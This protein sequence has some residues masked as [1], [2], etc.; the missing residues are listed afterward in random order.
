MICA[1]LSEPSWRESLMRIA[2][3]AVFIICALL[4]GL[5]FRQYAISSVHRPVGTCGA[6]RSILPPVFNEEPTSPHDFARELLERGGVYV[7]DSSSF[8]PGGELI[9]KASEVDRVRAR[10][11]VH[12]GVEILL[13][14]ALQDSPY[15]TNDPARAQLFVVPQFSSVEHLRCTDGGKYWNPCDDDVARYYLMPIIR[16]VQE[17]ATYKRRGGSDHLWIFSMDFGMDRF[18]G[19]SDALQSNWYWGYYGP[20][21]NHLAVPSP[22]STILSA[23]VVQSAVYS[24]NSDY[25]GTVDALAHPGF[26]GVASGL[27]EHARPRSTTYLAVF[28][29]T[30]EQAGLPSYSHGIRQ[31]LAALYPESQASET[32]VLVREPSPDFYAL[33][34]DSLFCLCP[35]G[36]A[37]WT[38]RVYDVMAAGCIPVLIDD[39]GFN[40]VLPFEAWIDWSIM[41]V[42]I[43]RSQ[44]RDIPALLEAIPAAEVCEKRR[45]MVKALPKLMWGLNPDGVLE[46]ALADAWRA[47][48][49]SVLAESPQ[50]PV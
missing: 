32:R 14:R 38:Q 36:L 34:R 15:L 1:Q 12:Y 31:E 13:I 16:G 3:P 4:F 7:Y 42:I 49:G 28:A 5:T 40:M 23:D 48:R 22:V 50:P 33:V 6:L 17:T 41:T 2:A 11:P 18:E 26:E 44:L 9:R 8:A 30:L 37:P 46:M 35:P 25:A 45:Y 27:C 21:N 43:P 39:P 10:M 20:H 24:P 29:G 47:I 19:V